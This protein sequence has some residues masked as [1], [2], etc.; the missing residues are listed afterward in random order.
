M[1][2]VYDDTAVSLSAHR[3][4]VQQ[5]CAKTAHR[6]SPVE[7]A[8]ITL[9]RSSVDCNKD[10]SVGDCHELAPSYP[11]NDDDKK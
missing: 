11:D 10:I 2:A 4:S 9:M 3:S 6:F 1:R 7:A 8:G 5:L